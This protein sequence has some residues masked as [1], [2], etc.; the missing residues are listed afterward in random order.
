MASR[1]SLALF[2]AITAELTGLFP[3][4]SKPTDP[5]PPARP[6]AALLSDVLLKRVNLL[7]N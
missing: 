6:V 1:R 4:P 3:P 7:R 2:F 5:T